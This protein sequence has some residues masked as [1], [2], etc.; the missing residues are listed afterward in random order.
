MHLPKG[1]CPM[2]TPKDTNQMVQILAGLRS[3]AETNGMVV[4]AEHLSDALMMVS[5]E[6]DARLH[7]DA[8]R[9]F[10]EDDNPG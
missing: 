9:V 7:Q 4:L 8:K 1:Y 6:A 2:Y 10:S 5:P 3:Y